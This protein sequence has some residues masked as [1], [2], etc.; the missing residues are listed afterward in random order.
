MAEELEPVSYNCWICCQE[1]DD[2]DYLLLPYADEYLGEDVS[3]FKNTF[4][5]KDVGP[6]QFL[7]YT[8]CSKCINDYLDL[9]G[10]IFKTVLKREIIGKKK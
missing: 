4:I 1:I 3:I 10:R 2:S 6:F 5:I 7:Y 9:H 8:C